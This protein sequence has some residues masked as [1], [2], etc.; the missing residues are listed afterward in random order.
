MAAKF[1]IDNL[2]ACATCFG[3]PG[4]DQVEAISLAI[5]FMVG[6]LIIVLGGIVGFMIVLKRRSRQMEEQPNT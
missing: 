3:N 4:D 1:S 5:L 6:V 2:L